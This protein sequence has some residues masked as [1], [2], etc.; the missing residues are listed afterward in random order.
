MGFYIDT[1]NSSSSFSITRL[2]S[3][4][5]PLSISLY[6]D[7]STRNHFNHK[8][9][10][11]KVPDIAILNTEFSLCIELSGNYKNV[12]N[13]SLALRYT[14]LVDVPRAYRSEVHDAMRG[15]CWS[16][17]L[18]PSVGEKTLNHL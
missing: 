17:L 16:Y 11:I 15:L 8:F 5:F 1:S 9:S 4:S 3:L 14:S 7:H 6:D 13:A 12:K 10:L 2:Y 18:Y